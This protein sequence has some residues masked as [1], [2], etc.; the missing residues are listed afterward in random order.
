MTRQIPV[1]TTQNV[2]LHLDIASL[3]DRIVA[4]L[5]DSVIRFVY[6]MAVL[7]IMDQFNGENPFDNHMVATLVILVPFFFYHLLFEVF[8]NG[9]SPGKRV[10]KLRVVRLDGQSVG[11]GSY[12]L[13]W[14]FRLID[15]NLFSGLVAI[16][17]IAA[18]DK[19]QRLG[20]MVAATTVVKERSDYNLRKLAFQET[21]PEYAL[22]YPEVF[23]LSSKHI[24][25]I[26][27]TLESRDIENIDSHVNL[28]ADKIADIMHVEF[29]GH[30][31]RFLRTVASDFS[32]YK[33][34]MP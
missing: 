28:L 2:D 24:Q 9:Q 8:N 4:Y 3:G 6:L 27:E 19:G 11:L 15:I 16:I 17:A 14:L 30:P 5:I 12:I 13:R 1:A 10:L 33:S 7:V 18:S 22:T 29:D 20:D 31:R 25:L 34:T 26:N 21:Q 32:H 23:R